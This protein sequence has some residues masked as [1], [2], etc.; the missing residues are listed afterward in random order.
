MQPCAPA[1]PPRPDPAQTI[2]NSLCESVGIGLKI[3]KQ[4]F[5]RRR[6][7][8]AGI[9]GIT[10]ITAQEKL[11]GLWRLAVL[12]FFFSLFAI[13]LYFLWLKSTRSRWEPEGK[14]RRSQLPPAFR[15]DVLGF[16]L[17]VGFGLIWGFWWLRRGASRGRGG[18][19]RELPPPL[20]ALPGGLPVPGTLQKLRAIRQSPAHRPP[21]SSSSP[22]PPPP[23]PPPRISAIAA[24]RTGDP[25]RGAAGLTDIPRFPPHTPG[26]AGGLAAGPQCPAPAEPLPSRGGPA[27]GGRC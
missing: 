25:H 10:Q 23:P 20:H 2:A 27:R 6:V 3:Q 21:P 22:P 1:L 9:T 4:E 26:R 7:P 16:F 8:R 14:T 13:F 19:A 17:P 18:R 12:F 24:I 15:W 5:K 11:C